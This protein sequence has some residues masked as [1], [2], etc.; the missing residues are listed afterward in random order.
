MNGENGRTT[1]GHCKMDS[2]EYYIGRGQNQ[3]HMLSDTVTPGDRGWLGNPYS[4]QDGFDRED[5]I[6]KFGKAFCDKLER[7][8]EFREAVHDLEGDTLGC[9]CQ[10]EDED[11][12]AC[13]GEV[14]AEYLNVR[15][16]SA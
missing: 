13:H 10:R 4:L 15:S 14:I 8:D 7:D 5:S 11:S 3:R 1:V 2:T 16:E 9:W 12:P 6:K